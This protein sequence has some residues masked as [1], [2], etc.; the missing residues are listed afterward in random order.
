MLLPLLVFERRSSCICLIL[1]AC[2]S[3]LVLE[4]VDVVV[5]VVVAVVFETEDVVAVTD[6][7]AVQLLLLTLTS[8][9]ALHILL[10]TS[11]HGEVGDTPGDR[12]GR[13]S[14]SVDALSSSLGDVRLLA[15]TVLG[16]LGDGSLG[17]VG[18]TGD[19][20]GDVSVCLGSSAVG[21]VGVMCPML[22]NA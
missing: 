4:G 13:R 21:D 11:L 18:L 19:R 7:V 9:A 17:E 2:L 5:A 16:S 14:S 12:L 10:V 3:D 20:S 6:D 1:S 22:G 8:S 15:R